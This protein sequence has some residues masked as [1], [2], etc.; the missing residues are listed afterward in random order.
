MSIHGRGS[1]GRSFCHSR[2]PTI[3]QVPVERRPLSVPPASS[4][5]GK[6]PPPDRSWFERKVDPLGGDHSLTTHVSGDTPPPS[7]R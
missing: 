5:N 6:T 1:R 3:T 2:T 7:L 4:V